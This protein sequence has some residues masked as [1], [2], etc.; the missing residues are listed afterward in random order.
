MAK[1][2]SLTMLGMSVN[3]LSG[4]FPPALYNLSSLQLIGLSFNKFRGTLRADIGIAFPNLQFLYLA[5]NYFIGVIPA[6]LSNATGL[7]RLDIPYNNFTGNVPMSFGSLQN[8]L[9]LNVLSNQLGRGAPD[10][11]DFVTSLCNCRKLALF[12]EAPGDL[13]DKIYWENGFKTKIGECLVS[14]LGLGVVCS[15]EAP[16]TRITAS[17]V[18]ADL[19][20]IRSNLSKYAAVQKRVQ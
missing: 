8:L 15:E 14:L 16:E 17:K 3:S 4:E 6:S 2:R 7:L 18:V 9:W 5:T 19:V 11:M 13:T 12:E 10:D 20:S 1:M